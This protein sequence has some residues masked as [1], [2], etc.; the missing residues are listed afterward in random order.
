M[1]ATEYKDLEHEA[2]E[3]DSAIDLIVNHVANTGN[4]VTQAEKDSWNA[5]ASSSDVAAE[6]LARQTADESLQAAIDGKADAGDLTSEAT[7]REQAD[8]SEAAARA[9][10]DA[11]HDS[12]LAGLIDGE[13]KNLLDLSTISQ[14]TIAGIT[15]TV[16]AAKGTITANGTATANSFFYIWANNSN[17]PVNYRSVLS[18]APADG[19]AT[20]HEI[21]AAIGLTVYHDYGETVQVPAGTIRYIT[22]CVRNGNTVSDLVFRPM[23]CSKA[24]YDLSEKFV[25]YHPS[26][27]ELYAMILALQS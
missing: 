9:A 27:S 16:D 5:K 14:Q 7:A 23:L 1:A 10:A 4:H 6:A 13:S 17:V 22:C 12:I 18:G 25:P 19:S 24:A 20:A 2:A 3:I 11:K 8:T 21:Q 26:I 15:W